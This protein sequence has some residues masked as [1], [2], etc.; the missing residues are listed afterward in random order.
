VWLRTLQLLTPLLA[1]AVVVGM[2]AA[3]ATAQSPGEVEVSVDA[4][5]VG[6]VVRPGDWAGVRLLLRDRGV[7]VRNVVVQLAVRDEDGDVATHQR[8]VTLN[9]GL[10]Q[11]QGVWLYPRLPFS[12]SKASQLLVTVRQASERDQP[13][14]LAA[15]RKLATVSI[16]PQQ[17]AAA[18]EAMI[19]VLGPR[20]MGLEQ[21]GATPPSMDQP[22]TTNELVRV[23]ADLAP[24]TL[25][26]AW[27]GLWP[28]ET[29]VWGRGDPAALSPS[30]RDALAQWVRRGGHLVVPMP[31]LGSTWHEPASN[32][33]YDLMP[34]VRIRR[35]E[36][37]SLEPLRSLLTGEGGPPLPQRAIWHT[38]TP[39]PGASPLDAATIL[40]TAQG[41]P[42]V[43][44]RTV[45]LGAVTLV[46]VDLASA[47][48]V[49]RIDAEVFWHRVLGKRGDLFTITEL[50]RQRTLDG[51]DISYSRL[52]DVDFLDGAV[53]ALINKSGS[54]GVGVIFGLVVFTAYVLLAGPVGFALLGALGMRQ[55]AWVVFVGVTAVFAVI[56]WGG[57]RALRPVTSS[58][59][60]L[61][62]LDH[63]HGQDQQRLRSWMS[64]FTPSYGLA[65][66]ATEDEGLS[67]AAQ[68]GPNALAP[69]DDPAE[70]LPKTFP[71]TQPYAV[72]TR[73]P[74]RLQLPA[75]ATVKRLQL[76]WA[77]KPLLP[78]PQPRN[79]GLSP[80]GAL[81][82]TLTHNLPGPL[83][84]V[85]VLLVRG[86]TPLGARPEGG[87]LL[88]VTRAWDPLGGEDWL[89][90]QPLDLAALDAPTPEASRRRLESAADYF[91]SVAA[92]GVGDLR[93]ADRS[94]EA[95]AWAPLLE[96]PDWRARRLSRQP[97][98]QRRAGHRMDLARW[99]TQPCLIVVGQL[100]E[101]ALPAPLTLDGRRVESQ[102]RVVVRWV[103]PLPPAP[104]TTLEAG[105]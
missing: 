14:R 67:S 29:I 60:H 53:A 63:V 32:P 95:L 20:T 57:A 90:G 45:G 8:I 10:S 74:Q 19:A 28:F 80:S 41:D 92:G 21:Y 12:F 22:A 77:G 104:P 39:N 66:L 27:M 16:A 75:R 103:Y 78:M 38:F 79:V 33:L 82:G 49:G 24:E 36:G 99:F 1:G 76:D 87:P 52:P 23:V 72:D 7:A 47:E 13:D 51:R 101:A 18:T 15:G 86:Q 100:A 96:P 43:V 44:R 17:V 6:G 62:L 5:G 40:T 94:V 34:A 37:A 93:T 11:G 88:A 73:R 64:V 58:I 85:R 48:L 68:F 71:D 46:G 89:P 2:T 91:R 56:A 98:V 55:H 69:W 31:A 81:Q 61:T 54:A 26:D 42:V 65:T 105:R 102:G 83:Q 4:F 84:R 50:Q 9:P 25:P 3:P 35:L 97:L 30:A 59:R 70:L